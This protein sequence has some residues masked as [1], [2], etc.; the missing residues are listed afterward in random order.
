MKEAAHSIVNTVDF[1]Q[2]R[3]TDFP[4]LKREVNGKPLVYLD[5]A[6]S[7]QMPRQVADRLDQYHRME[8]ANV[9]RGIHTLSQLA[10][11]AFE[12][13]RKKVRDF[14]NAQSEDEIIYTTGTT[15]SINL[16]ANSLGRS[17][18]KEGDE[19]LLS[20]MEHHANIVP[21]QMI[22]QQTGAVI[23]VIP[24]TDQGDIN[25]GAFNDLLSERTRIVSVVHV[26][27]ALGTVNPVKEIT[28]L[29][30][31]YDAYVVIDGAQA[32]PH[33]KVNVQDLNC[34]FYAFSA[35][36]M[37]GPT[38]FGILFGKKVHLDRMPPYRGGGDM[39]DKVSFEETTYNIAPFKF[40]AGTPPIA[41]G[42][43]LGSAIDYL[44][45]IG[46]DQIARREQEIVD[47][48]LEKLSYVDGI[49]LFATPKE[50]AS[51]ISFTFGDIHAHDVGTILDKQGIAIRTGHHCAQ[52]ILQRFGVSATARASFSFYNNKEDADRLIDGLEYVKGF[53][54]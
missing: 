14:I 48:A 29:A 37:C 10:T 8:H 39:I 27:N 7:S 33:Q 6:A 20:E 54:E 3:N 15:D 26:S 5:N 42:I 2:I 44:N 32:I 16:V 41:A 4:V 9:H 12:E 28:N 35:H 30:H 25:L 11:D 1:D 38:G 21:W 36:K 23:K 50:R 31:Q 18:L 43:G 47:Y 53:F 17:V 24:V 19:I 51:V 40:E 34:D 13:T 52:P 49:K 46:M 45:E 22:A